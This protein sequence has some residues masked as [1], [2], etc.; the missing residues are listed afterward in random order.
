M[1]HPRH[2]QISAKDGPIRAN[3]QASRGAA[4][5]WPEIWYPEPRLWNEKR[6]TGRTFRYCWEIMPQSWSIRR[7]SS[8]PSYRAIGEAKSSL[9]PES[10][11]GRHRAGGK[12]CKLRGIISRD[13][14][15][16]RVPVDVRRTFRDSPIALVFTHVKHSKRPPIISPEI[17]EAQQ[18]ANFTHSIP[19]SKPDPILRT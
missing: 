15:P 6:V 19:R 11:P 3:F 16:G 17:Q 1:R 9:F 12:M 2:T 4:P 5:K 7:R 13:W 14:G 8:L 10:S 18:P